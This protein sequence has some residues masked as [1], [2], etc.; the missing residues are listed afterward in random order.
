MAFLERFGSSGCLAWCY[1]YIAFVNMDF[2]TLV[3]GTKGP[4]DLMGNRE[5]LSRTKQWM[6]SVT[7]TTTSASIS[8][9]TAINTACQSQSLAVDFE[10]RCHYSYFDS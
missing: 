3:V 5:A 8:V 4:L 6:T 7:T 10:L 9:H 2:I 1:H